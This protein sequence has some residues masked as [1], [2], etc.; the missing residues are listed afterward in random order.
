MAHYAFLDENN[1]VTQ[2]IPGNDGDEWETF[3]A[4]EVGQVCKRTSYNTYG[5]SHPNGTPFRGNY[6]GIGFTYDPVRDAFIAPKP[7][8]NWILDETTFLWVEV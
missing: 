1:I 6:A 2:V 7:E 4:Q 8:G 3:Y 5:N